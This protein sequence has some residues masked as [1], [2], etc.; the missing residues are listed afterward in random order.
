MGL[1]IGEVGKYQ[2]SVSADGNGTIYE[3]IFDTKKGGVVSRTKTDDEDYTALPTEDYGD[4]DD[5]DDD[6]VDIDVQ[7]WALDH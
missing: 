6:V 1:D 5:D 3:V 2:I 4:D 7:R